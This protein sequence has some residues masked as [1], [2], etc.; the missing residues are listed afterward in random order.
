MTDVDIADASGPF[1]LLSAVVFLI[2][3]VDFDPSFMIAGLAR[4][5]EEREALAGPDQ[6]GRSSRKQV[7]A[8]S[9]RNRQRRINAYVFN[10]GEKRILFHKQPC[11]HVN[12]IPG[13]FFP[14][15]F[16]AACLPVQPSDLVLR[17]P[18]SAP[19]FV[20]HALRM[21]GQHVIRE[22]GSSS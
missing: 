12:L 16:R 8:R 10:L 14:L 15:Q 7:Y 17:A 4:G 3:I 6:D 18:E 2:S 11:G 1:D 21:P 20:R 9:C 5:S 22:R 13:V 19:V